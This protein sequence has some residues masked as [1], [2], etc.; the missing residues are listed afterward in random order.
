M[1]SVRVPLQLDPDELEKLDEICLAINASR[2]QAIRM[3][4]RREAIEP[5]LVTTS[6]RAGYRHVIGKY[7]NAV[8]LDVP[9][10]RK[11]HFYVYPYRSNCCVLLLDPETHGSVPREKLAGKSVLIDRILDLQWS[12]YDWDT[13]EFIEVCRLVGLDPQDRR[14]RYVPQFE[15]IATG[16]VNRQ[17]K[18]PST[19]SHHELIL[20]LLDVLRTD[21]EADLDILD[22]ARN[23]FETLSD[24]EKA[25][26]YIEALD[27]GESRKLKSRTISKTVITFLPSW[28]LIVGLTSVALWESPADH[29]DEDG[30]CAEDNKDL[31]GVAV[32]PAGKLS[33]VQEIVV[34]RLKRQG[35]F[36]ISQNEI[37]DYLQG[38]GAYWYWRNGTKG[39]LP[40]NVDK[41][42]AT[43][44]IK[45]HFKKPETPFYDGWKR[46]PLLR[47]G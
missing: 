21:I 47:L 5:R 20:D 3:M 4:I 38:E 41:P 11:L 16:L 28:S 34:D 22:Q 18:F 27:A 7:G 29:C 46:R 30:W 14:P 12:E 1:K 37:Y 40:F 24:K 35:V 25:D 6:D 8:E 33:R 36:M 45:W 13:P 2:N 26:I 19:S 44:I 31:E 23:R 15:W 42:S 32:V 39:F 10:G 43:D 9:D 17:K